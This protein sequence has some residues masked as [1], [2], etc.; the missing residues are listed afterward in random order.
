MME[1]IPRKGLFAVLFGSLALNLFFG[2]LFFA[3]WLAHRDDDLRPLGAMQRMEAAAETLNASERQRAAE[4][5]QRHAP[6]IQQRIL[7]VRKARKDL[8]QQLTARAL[9]RERLEQAITTLTNHSREAKEEI[10]TM[11]REMATTL[12]PEARALYFERFGK[13]HHG[14]RM[15]HQ[16]PIDAKENGV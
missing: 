11:M 16:P 1:T 8:N 7:A 10:Y 3:K 14:K 12:S 4:I 2:G 15:H 5:H 13:Q 9:D 6:V